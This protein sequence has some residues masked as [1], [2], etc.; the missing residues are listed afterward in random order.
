VGAT[1]ATGATGPSGITIEAGENTITAN[2]T[3]TTLDT[4][5]LTSNGAFE[6]ILRLVQGSN[7]RV[8][9]VFIAKSSDGSTVDHTEYAVIEL[10]SS[11]SGVEVQATVSGTNL[12]LQAKASNAATTNVTARVARTIL[13]T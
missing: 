7:I 4:I 5:T 13:T 9:K 1:G 6:Y 2:D 3:W 11:I 8:S 12:L 10:G